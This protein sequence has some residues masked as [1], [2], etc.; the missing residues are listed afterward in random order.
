[1]LV[2]QVLIFRYQNKPIMYRKISGDKLKPWDIKIKT[3]GNKLE[4]TIHVKY[5]GILIDSHLNWKFHVID[6]SIKLSH[7]VGMLAKIRHYINQ[8][9]LNMIYHRIF[10]SLLLYGSQIWGQSN[11]SIS[12]MVKLQNKALKIISFKHTRSS[13]NPLYSK[14]EIL[15][16][17]DNIKLSN[18]LFAHDSIE[19]N[20][21]TLWI[22]LHL[23]TINILQEIKKQIR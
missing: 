22:V 5:L 12:K 6:L 11:T 20:L 17:A 18:F 13:V 15:K 19:S 1:M 16:F 8:R 3:D 4:P 14:C 9:T 21:P 10:S 23:C 7:T 2:K